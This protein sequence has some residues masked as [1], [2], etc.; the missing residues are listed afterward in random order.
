MLVISACAGTSNADIAT[1]G[2]ADSGDVD[3]SATETTA[4][5]TTTTTTTTTIPPRPPADTLTMEKLTRITGDI[6]PKSVVASGTGVVT[7][8][9]MMYR[10]TVTAYDADGN[11]ISTIPDTVTLSDFG[12][13]EEGEYQGAPVE[14]AFM[15]DGEEVYISNYSMYGPGYGEGSDKCSPGD[16]TTNSFLY[17]I[18]TESWQVDQVIPAGAVPKYVAVTPDGSKVLATN[19]CTYDM[20]I[21][22][23]ETGEVLHTVPIDG[24]YPRGIAI[25]PE[26]TIAYVAVMGGSDIVAVDIESGTVDRRIPVGAGPR[27]LVM[28][29][30]GAY[31]YATLNKEGKVAKI[32]LISGEVVSKVATGQQPRSMDISNDGRALYVVNYASDDVSKLATEDM[33]ILQTVPAGH[34]PIGITY[35]RST[36]RVWV[37]NY[38]GSIDV[39]DEVETPA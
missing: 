36:G 14:A 33:S 17:R 28:S 24:R 21:A 11:L 10:H 30:D 39:W 32:N 38:S 15:P 34:H 8:Q 18:N 12:I 3:A 25:N 9:N 26:G 16:G 23:T 19:W 29:P 1:P 35:D 2:E 31:L 6:S 20:T 4:G 7:A 13:D 22:D 27:H 5:P 37:A